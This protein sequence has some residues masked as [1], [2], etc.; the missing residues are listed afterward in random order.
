MIKNYR[1][2]NIR[3]SGEVV[4]VVFEKNPSLLH[5]INKK[6]RISD[7]I[8]VARGHAWEEF[9]LEESDFNAAIIRDIGKKLETPGRIM[10]KIIEANLCNDDNDKLM[11]SIRNICG[12]YA[13][14]VSPYIY[15]LSLSNTNSRRSRAGST[16]QSI[17]YKTYDVLG[18]PFDSQKKVGKKA[19][20]EKGLGKIV[21]SILPGIEAFEQRRDKTIIGSMKTSLRERWQEV[22]EEISRT[23]IPNIF[24][25][26]M[27]HD[28]SRNKAEQMSHHN[29]I[30][31]VQPEV[32]EN[33]DVKEMKNI[34]SFEQYFFEEIPGVLKFW[35]Q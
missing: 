33:K 15:M 23:N 30:L 21:D 9:L 25:L 3:P 18:Y 32:I 14:R 35:K 29:I 13:G 20:Q 19:F 1:K 17:I 12:E 24:L 2:K 6:G 8:G 27:D 10:D 28:I 34:I 4:D 22:S 26:T 31:V 11:E 7:V 16:F 5:Q